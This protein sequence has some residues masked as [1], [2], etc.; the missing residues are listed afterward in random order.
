MGAIINAQEGAGLDVVTDGDSRF[1]LEVGGKSWFFTGPGDW[2]HSR[3]EH[4]LA[5]LTRHDT[6]WMVNQRMR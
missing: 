2:W 5:G 6:A 3:S 1:D 4:H